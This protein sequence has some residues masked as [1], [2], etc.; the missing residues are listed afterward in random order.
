LYKGLKCKKIG[1]Y[2]RVLILSLKA[3][4]K[5]VNKMLQVHKTSIT[6][7]DKVEVE[8]HVLYNVLTYVKTQSSSTSMEGRS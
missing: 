3:Q 6:T 5:G 7:E 2:V 8:Q 1:R 4:S